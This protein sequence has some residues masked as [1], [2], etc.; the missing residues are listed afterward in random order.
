MMRENK[1]HTEGK[2]A[3]LGN[4]EN[5]NMTSVLTEELKRRELEA[6]EL[7]RAKGEP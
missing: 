1:L 5:K 4:K 7:K 3:R 2:D 6:R